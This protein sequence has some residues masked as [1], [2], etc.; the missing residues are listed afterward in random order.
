MKKFLFGLAI[1][2]AGLMFTSCN[3]TV[4]G[5]VYDVSIDGNANGNVV[6]TFPNGNLDL[7]GNVDLTFKYSNDTTIV[8]YTRN[9]TTIKG[10]ADPAT[11]DRKEVQE[12]NNAVNESFGVRFK[13]AEAGG[14][15]C[16]HIT[17][18]A[19]EPT[20]GIVIAIDKTFQ[21]PPVNE[22]VTE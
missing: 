8:Q 14:S 5:F 11:D 1:V 20:T 4:N 13:D 15:Y 3:D 21:Y 19:K 7:D 16:V 2:F 17:G 10:F 9:S 22:E 12:L 6:V 18:Y